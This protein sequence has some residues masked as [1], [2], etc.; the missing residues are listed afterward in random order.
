MLPY[1]EEWVGGMK[2]KPTSAYGIRLYQNSTTLACHFDKIQTH[3]ISSIVHIDHEYDEESQPWPIEIED[4]DGNLH[5]V[6]LERGQT[7]FYESSNHLHCRM[8][9]FRGKYYG[10]IFLHYQPVDPA[11][12]DYNQE[13][14]IA[15]VPPHW[16]DGATEEI[17]SRWSGQ[18]ITVDSR[19]CEGLPP[20][21]QPTIRSEFDL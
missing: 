17:G 5:S 20:R 18:A 10:S 3:V 14:I 13:M 12:W 16:R 21:E 4:H 11:I 2:L 6:V 8:T 9:K 1:H 15:N 7:L 19:A